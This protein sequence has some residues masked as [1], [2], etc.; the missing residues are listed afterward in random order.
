MTAYELLDKNDQPY[1]PY[2]ENPAVFI[3]TVC[4]S[5]NR[6]KQI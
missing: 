6:S 3:R 4:V 1:M 5:Y 2:V